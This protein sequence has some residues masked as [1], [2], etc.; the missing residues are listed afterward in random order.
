M[1]RIRYG[2]EDCHR[3]AME[4]GCGGYGGAVL[5]FPIHFHRSDS[6]PRVAGG[7]ERSEECFDA[8]HDFGRDKQQCPGIK[9]PW[10]AALEIN[11]THVL[12]AWMLVVGIVVANIIYLPPM[13]TDQ[14]LNIRSS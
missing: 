10:V 11:L 14:R 6:F 3:I 2:G 13:S 7:G 5:N 8:V 9:N 1:C 12:Y 4:R